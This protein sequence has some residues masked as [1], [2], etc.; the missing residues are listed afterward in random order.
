[1]SCCRIGVD[2][3]GRRFG[4]QGFRLALLGEAQEGCHFFLD[5]DDGFGLLQTLP[6]N[7]IFAT[8]LGQFGGNRVDGCFHRAALERLESLEGPCIALADAN[9]SGL[10]SK[11][12]HGAR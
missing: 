2:K 10:T 1:M 7:D 8:N 9:R 6:Q 3:S 11:G 5:A 4:R 12:F